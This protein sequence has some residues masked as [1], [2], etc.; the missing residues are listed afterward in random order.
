M[1]KNES[2]QT[3]FGASVARYLEQYQPDKTRLFNDNIVK[4]LLP[5]TFLMFLKIKGIR[6]WLIKVYDKTTKGLYGGLVCRTKYIDEAIRVI[7]KNNIQQI[8]ILG[9]GLDTRP[10]RMEELKNIKDFEVDL[11]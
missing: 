5:N 7:Q 8:I 4:H 10:Y 6:N 9:S 1:K 2:G 3:A 11:A